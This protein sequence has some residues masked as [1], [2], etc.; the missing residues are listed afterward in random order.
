MTSPVVVDVDSKLVRVSF[1]LPSKARVLPIRVSVRERP[2]TARPRCRSFLPPPQHS[3]SSLPAP[4]DPRVALRSLPAYTA[5]T[6]SYRAGVADEKAMRR[7]EATLR[8][9]L[10]AE[11]LAPLGP[12]VLLEYSPPW[13]LPFLRPVE[14][15]LRLPEGT[16]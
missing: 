16:Q 4:S 9:A 6:V 5:A 2:D 13:Q 11:G 12:L 3:L 7:A 15:M 10:A 14:V 8:A 1:V